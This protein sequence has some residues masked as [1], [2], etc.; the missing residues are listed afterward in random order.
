MYV[1]SSREVMLSFL[2]TLLLS[3]SSFSGFQTT[4]SNI[5]SISIQTKARIESIVFKT[6]SSYSLRYIHFG[7]AMPF[8]FIL[9]DLLIVYTH[10]REPCL[11]AGLWKECIRQC[12][13]K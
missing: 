3:C 13:I 2:Y 12:M 6:V 8:P 11:C 4:L 9:Y 7:I 1:I 5:L 10:F